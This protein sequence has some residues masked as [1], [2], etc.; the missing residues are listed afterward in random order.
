MNDKTITPD[1]GGNSFTCPRCFANSH[2]TWFRV[3]LDSYEKDN[4]P[5]IPDAELIESIEKENDGTDRSALIKYFKRK[6]AKE[7]FHDHHS[8]DHYLNDELVNL[9]ISRCY[10][11]DNYAVWLADRLIY[12]PQQTS[13]Q[14]NVEMP[15][16]VC[17]D[18]LEAT[19]I[20]EITYRIFR[21][22][23]IDGFF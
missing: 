16:D 14:P 7:L 19:S 23:R 20:V 9:S 2:Q 1:L 13:I 11:C 17:L 8:Q 4:R 6:I 15:P 12:P 22:F 10:S 21:T 5:W 18:F 3:F